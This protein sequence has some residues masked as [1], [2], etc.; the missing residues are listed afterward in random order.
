GQP[1]FLPGAPGI[2]AATAAPVAPMTGPAPAPDIAQPGVAPVTQAR[3]PLA[4]TPLDDRSAG[5]SIV[6]DE[7]NNAMGITA[8][9][10]EYQR[11]RRILEQI[12]VQPNQVL[13]EATIAEVTLTDQLAMGVR[14]FLQT[15]NFAFRFTDLGANST[16]TTGTTTPASTIP[17][18]VP[19]F[20]G[21]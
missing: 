9:A 6:A 21:F 12:D 4:A 7:S 20:P 10:Q 14:W 8:S 11:M 15:G 17:A 13:L 2:P 19:A 18:V 5:I 16:S 1:P 3:P